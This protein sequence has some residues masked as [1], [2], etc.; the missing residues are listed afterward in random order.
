[1]AIEHWIWFPAG[2]VVLGVLY[3]L[4]GT[5]R[6]RDARLDRDYADEEAAPYDSPASQNPVMDQYMRILDRD[7]RPPKY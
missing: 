6:F 5:R 7:T 3:G 1:M 2:G 4:Y